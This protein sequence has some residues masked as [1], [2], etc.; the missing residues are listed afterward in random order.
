MRARSERLASVGIFASGI[1]HELNN[2]LNSIYLMALYMLRKRGLAWDPET[3]AKIKDEAQRGGQIVK[4]VLKLAQD[5][6]SPRTPCNLQDCVQRAVELLKSYIDDSRVDL[7]IEFSPDLPALMLNRVEIEQV[8]LNILK[9]AV[10]STGDRIHV[11]VTAAQEGQE[12]IL[13]IWN[14]GPVIPQ[15]AC[16][17]LFDAFFTTRRTS[18]GCGLGLSLCHKIVS[19]HGGKIDVVSTPEAGTTFRIRLPLCPV[20]Q[21]IMN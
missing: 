12:E 17:H 6:P 14:D 1:A 15:E 2:P 18:G 8:V 21:A 10:Q 16:E 7:T 4:N 5:Q 11:R 20:R 13:R 3:V 9:N 19:D